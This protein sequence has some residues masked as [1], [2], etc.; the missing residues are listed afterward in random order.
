MSKDYYKILGIEKSASAEEIKKAFRKQAHVHHPDKTNGSAEKFKE[1]NEAYQIL[2]NADK[3]KQYDQ[4]GDSAFQGQG[5]GG[6][7]MN[8]QDF[9]RKAQQSSQGGQ[10]RYED[11]FGDFSA[12]GGSS[13]GWDFGD[14]GDIFGDIG[15]MF[16][17][18]SRGGQ[19]ARRSGPSQGES[20]EIEMSI[21]FEEAVFGAQREIRLSRIVKCEKCKG[22][23]AQP[24]T[25]ISACS[26]CNGKGQVIHTRSTMFGTF[27]TASTCSE[28]N[29]EGKSADVPCGQCHGQGRIEKQEN[30][31]I[32][33]PAGIDNSQTVRMSGLG[34]AG[35]RGGA[36]GDL[37]IHVRVK[38]HK[39]FVREGFDIITSEL[40]LVS[41]AVLGDT[42]QVE[43]VHGPVKLKI[44]A[45]TQ[46]NTKFKLRSKGVPHINSDAKGDHIVIAEIQIPKKLSR[47]EKKLYEELRSEGL[48]GG[49]F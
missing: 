45:G 37:Y 44:P 32:N 23:G 5:F 18:S 10:A 3:R 15:D 34:N 41:Q 25:K 19:G 48:R 35:E 4:F 16:G 12:K 26:R 40:I 11:G 22:N 13:S 27:Q 47:K 14:I 43:T 2:G 49:W 7:G 17:F 24:G 8:W 1:A 9:V 29:G 36:S 28:C 46:P 31:K 20:M 39:R 30:V 21:D 33:I 6:T 38:P 42:I